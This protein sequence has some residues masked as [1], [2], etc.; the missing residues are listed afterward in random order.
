MLTS[1]I[2]ISKPVIRGLYGNR[3]LVLLAG[4]KFDNQQWQEEHGLGLSSFGLSKVELIKGPIGILYGTEAIGGIVNLIEEKG[5]LRTR[6]KRILGCILIPIHWGEPCRQ[7]TRPGKET[8][9]GA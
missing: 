5:R 6:G 2:A 7:D 4:L 3:I 9:G 8:G 1:G